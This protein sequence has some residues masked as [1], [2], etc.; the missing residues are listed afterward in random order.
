MMLIGLTGGIAS[1]KTFVSECFCALGVHV[2]DA[3]QLAREVVEPGSDGLSA[4][5]DHFSNEILLPSGELDRAALRNI[6]FGNEHQ[7]KILDDTLHPRI[8]VLSEQRIAEAT[9]RKLDYMIYAVPLLV[10]TEQ[11]KRF[12]RIAV[13]DVPEA[14]QLQRLMLRDGSSASQAKAILDA[15]ASRA[16]RLAIADDVIDNAGSQNNTRLQVTALHQSYSE[17]AEKP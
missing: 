3:D 15:Q 17:K 4:L 16:Q 11:Q 10:E 5:V 13:V 7:R 6:V 12:D 9:D 1:G 14:L 8:R 2:L